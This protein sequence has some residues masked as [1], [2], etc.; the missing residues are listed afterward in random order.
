MSFAYHSYV[1]VYYLYGLICYPYVTRMYS[2]VIR[3]SL[4]CARMSS[5]CM[6]LVCH[7]YVI[8]LQSYVIRMSLICTRMLSV[9]HLYVLVCHPY[10]TSMYSGPSIRHS[11]WGGI[12]FVTQEDPPLLGPTR[13]RE[14]WNFD[15][16]DWLKRHSPPGKKMTLYFL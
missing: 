14:F 10:V 15:P 16:L 2:H 12:K 3:M 8:C 5:V 13:Q 11:I 1:L 7:P 9:C 6:W 4:V